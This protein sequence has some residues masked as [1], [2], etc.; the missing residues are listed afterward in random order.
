MGVLVSFIIAW[1]ISPGTTGGVMETIIG[2]SLSSLYFLGIG[3]SF[4]VEKK[5][6]S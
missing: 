5:R 4:L 1:I 2:L 6:E 3:I